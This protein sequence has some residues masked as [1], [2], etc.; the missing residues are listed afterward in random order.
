MLKFII[1]YF[2]IISSC[3]YYSLIE[4]FFDDIAGLAVFIVF[5]GIPFGYGYGYAAAVDRAVKLEVD[6]H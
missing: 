6:A 2:F 3:M 4:R 5:I 1:I